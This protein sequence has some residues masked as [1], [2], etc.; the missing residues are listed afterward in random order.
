MVDQRISR[1]V[2]GQK[3]MKLTLRYKGQLL[4]AHSSNR[5]KEKHSIRKYLHDQLAAY[6]QQNQRLAAML[7][8]LKHLQIAHRSRDSFVVDRPLSDGTKFWWRWPLCGYDF[9]PLVTQ[10][11][12]THWELSI[13][14]YRKPERSGFLFAGGDIDNTVKTFLDALQVPKEESQVPNEGPIHEKSI[15]WPPL[16][17]MFDD[18][19]VVTKLTIESFKLLTPIPDEFAGAEENYVEMDVDIIINPVIPMMGTVDLLFQ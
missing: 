15:N 3:P 4:S 11:H 8:D 16:F 5:V 1:T 7:A 12:G 10:I 18:D 2:S 6:W 9:I 14:L 13:R 17:C 19:K